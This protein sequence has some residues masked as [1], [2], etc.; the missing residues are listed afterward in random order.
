MNY[1]VYQTTN[2]L[3][4]RIYIGKHK[5]S[6]LND[7]YMGSGKILLEAIAKYGI[8]NFKRD[9]LFNFDNEIDMNAKE[10]ELVDQSFIDRKDTYNLCFGGNGG[11]GY[12]NKTGIPKFI[13]KKHSDDTKE[14]IRQKSLGRKHTDETKEKMTNNHWSKKDPNKQ[15]EHARKAASAPRPNRR[16]K[17][18]DVA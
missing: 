6:N 17:I 5:T 18:A 15:R 1:I 13:G 8:E 14:I 3:N 2:L 9:I 11:F 4:G 12:I 10:A 16:K 7:G